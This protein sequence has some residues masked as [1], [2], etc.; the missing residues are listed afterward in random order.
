[1]IDDRRW[2]RAISTQDLLRM[3]G[4]AGIAVIVVAA[5][6]VYWP[7]LHGGFVLDD[8]IYLTKNSLIEAPD[9]LYRFWL[10]KQPI[11]CYPASNTSLWIEWR[12]WGMN[13]T[14]YHVTNLMLHIASCLVLWAILLR[15][16]LPAAFLAAL[17]YAIHPINIE[18]VAWIAQR[19]DVMAVFLALVSMLWYLKSDVQV[20]APGSA[21]YAAGT[22]KW[23]WL[24]VGA[25]ALAMLSKGSVAMLPLLLLLD[26]KSVV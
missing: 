17:L 25:F 1:M 22:V 4:L 24:S 5:L 2:A 12:L 7:A 9:G 3:R 16:G 13:S 20:E 18:S 10:T 11:D 21:G 23:Y 6:I 15:L 14:G 8:D 26:R 19:K